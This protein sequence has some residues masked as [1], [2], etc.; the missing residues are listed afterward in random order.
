MVEI[1]IDTFIESGAV[2]RYK[3]N[4]IH[5]ML[6]ITT[7]MILFGIKRFN[8]RSFFLFEYNIVTSLYYRS[9]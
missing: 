5:Q 2:L 1:T 8:K 7:V 3:I 6:Y 4:D 9:V